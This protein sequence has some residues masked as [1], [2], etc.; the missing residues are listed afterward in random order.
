MCVNQT[1]TKNRDFRR[2]SPELEQQWPLPALN[3]C[4]NRMQPGAPL[5]S[6][7][8]VIYPSPLLWTS[9]ATGPRPSPRS[10]SPSL[11]AWRSVWTAFPLQRRRFTAG[12]AMKGFRWQIECMPAARP[13]TC[14]S[15]L[16]VTD[17][18]V[19]FLLSRHKV[20]RL[21]CKCHRVTELSTEPET[22][23]PYQ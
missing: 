19:T 10:W 11:P 23:I 16:A 5:S 17:T 13:Q 6:P 14:S 21:N 7:T 12:Q 1:T 4:F 3:L 2:Q 18:C 22:G 20:F 15:G 9:I 8:T